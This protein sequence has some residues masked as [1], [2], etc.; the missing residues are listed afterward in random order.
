MLNRR[1]AGWPSLRAAVRDERGM[2]MVMGVGVG[3]VVFVLGVT[4]A[5]LAQH[6]VSSSAHERAREQAFHAAEAGVHRAMSLLADDPD[7]TSVSLASLDQ[8]GRVLG[9]YEAAIEAPFGS[10]DRRR[11]V[12]STGY[13]PSRDADGRVARR[14][15]ALVEFAVLD[16]FAF[17]LFA[18]PD[19]VSARENLI[20]AGDVYA[21]SRASWGLGAQL[22]GDVSSWAGIVSEGTVTGT[23]RTVGDVDVDSGT[24]N[25]DVFAAE[26]DDG[27]GG[28]VDVT[29]ATVTGQVWARHT[30]GPAANIGGSITTGSQPPKPVDHD[31]PTFDEGPYLPWDHNHGNANNFND[32]FEDHHEEFEGTH[33]VTG[34]AAGT[35]ELGGEDIDSWTMT[36][37]VVLYVRQRPIRLSADVV[38]GSSPHKV[39]TLVV[40]SERDTDTAIELEGDVSIPSDI[41]VLV[42]GPEAKVEADDGDQELH[43]VVYG[44]DIDLGDSFDISHAGVDHVDGFDWP[45]V[46][47]HQRVQLRLFKEVP[48]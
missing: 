16:E 31:L 11:T 10:D 47:A 43:G 36:D 44:K 37:D 38:N 20:V 45:E 46:G 23:L 30:A 4:F 15:E 9:E 34:N 21:E 33:R 42:F 13:S 48:V 3:A 41:H 19:D 25:G 27:S 35:V 26:D 8:D 17:A 24:V 7:T 32:Y 28:D 5:Q 6:Q 22:T 39:L 12:T 14:V 29:G 2:G 40:I 1:R 18:E